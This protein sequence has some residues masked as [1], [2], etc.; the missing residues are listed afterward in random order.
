MGHCL[1]RRQQRLS[2]QRLGRPLRRARRRIQH[3]VPREL[4]RLL[5][6]EDGRKARQGEDAAGR[7][8]PV[9]LRG[10]GKEQ[11]QCPTVHGAGVWSVPVRWE[12]LWRL[13]W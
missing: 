12:G 3:R 9:R 11:G 6:L 2:L 4:L 7:D 10:Q 5:R 13:L 8:E 1:G